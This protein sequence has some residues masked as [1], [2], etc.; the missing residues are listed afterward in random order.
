MK[1]TYFDLE[2]DNLYWEATKVHCIATLNDE[3]GV[4]L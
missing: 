1:R 2:A 3:D 4:K